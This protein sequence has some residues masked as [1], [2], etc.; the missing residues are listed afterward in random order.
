MTILFIL[1]IIQTIFAVAL[2][3]ISNLF[4]IPNP[5][6]IAAST[7]NTATSTDTDSDRCSVRILQFN[8]FNI[9]GRFWTRKPMM[10][11][12]LRAIEP[13]IISLNEAVRSR[14]WKFGTIPMLN[15]LWPDA[16]CDSI[17]NGGYECLHHKFPLIFKYSFVWDHVIGELQLAL[18][19]VFVIPFLRQW[20][21]RALLKGNAVADALMLFAGIPCHFGN[22]LFFRD[23]AMNHKDGLILSCDGLKTA[24]RALFVHPKDR[25]KRA[26]IVNTHLTAAAEARYDVERQRMEQIEEI[27]EWMK[28][29]ASD[30][31]AD[32]LVICGDFNAIPDSKTYRFMKSNGFK[33]C[34]CCH[35]GKGEYVTYESVAW[36]FAKGIDED[37]GK[38]LVLDYVW[39]KPLRE[40]VDLRIDD[41]RIVGQNFV[42]L[43]HRGEDIKVCPSDHY[44]VFVTLSW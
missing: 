29:A 25:R 31:P 33:S 17:S 2:Y 20:G 1:W 24:N 11:D 27:L 6:M 3:L 26:W 8:A 16:R 5:T 37:V 7:I 32:A 12:M 30:H 42:N 21:W 23:S 9:F 35:F 14:I 22:I 39:I 36:T 19:A 15:S 10:E 34:G 40:G 43:Q 28:A 38:L 4:V 18:N 13:D 41:C 44:G